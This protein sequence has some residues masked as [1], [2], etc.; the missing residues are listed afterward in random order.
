MALQMDLSPVLSSMRL[1]G[2][3]NG[4]YTKAASELNTGRRINSAAGDASGLSI[5][6][7]MSTQIKSFEIA[8]KNNRQYVDAMAMYDGIAES[9]ESSFLRMRQLAVYADN[10]SLTSSQRASLD[11]EFQSLDDFSDN[12]IL[13]SDYNGN[14][15]FTILWAA[16]LSIME[17]IVGSLLHILMAPH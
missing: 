1:L 7:R 12:A 10:G 9:D 3:N 4:A 15:F 11:A 8:I 5:T 14:R 2:I 17:L 6:E 13:S 16:L